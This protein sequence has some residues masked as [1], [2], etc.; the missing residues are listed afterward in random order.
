MRAEIRSSTAAVLAYGAEPSLE[1]GSRSGT[2]HTF[3]GGWTK[4]TTLRG[5]PL[6]LKPLLDAAKK[7]ES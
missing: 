2:I 3:S 7:T 5:G 6:S 1:I 4:Q